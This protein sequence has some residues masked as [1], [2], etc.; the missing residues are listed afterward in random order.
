MEEKDCDIN[1]V[2][3]SIAQTE[4]RLSVEGYNE[5]YECGRREGVE[6]GYHLG[7][8]RGA[9]LGAEL[10]FYAGVVEAWLSVGSNS[11]SDKAQQSLNKVLELVQKF[12]R[13]NVDTIDL[14]AA[15]DLIRGSFKRACALL[16]TS[17][18]YPET[19][20]LSF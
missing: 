10:G 11:M 16:K 20:K 18:S 15:V 19:S 8:H 4:N 17:S 2:F 6:E 1:T 9:E 3:D 12:P 13:T 14:L 7:Y 5:G